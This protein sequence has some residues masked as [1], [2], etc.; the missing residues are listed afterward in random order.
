MAPEIVVLELGSNDLCDESCD[1]LSV[2][3]AIEAVVELLHKDMNVR[4]TMVCEVIPRE[5]PPYTSHRG[6][7]NPAVNIYSGTPL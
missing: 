2:S 6:L 1:A 5:R 4:F 3:L 7:S